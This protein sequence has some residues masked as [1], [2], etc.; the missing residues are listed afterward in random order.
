MFKPVVIFYSIFLLYAPIL[1]ADDSSID[2]E[3][4]YELAMRY[5][6]GL[7]NKEGQP[8][9]KKA[10]S[11][12]EATVEQ[13]HSK[14]MYALAWLYYNGQGDIEPNDELAMQLFERA[15]QNDL[16]EAQYMLGIMYAQGRGGVEKNSQLSLQWMK[17]AADQEYKPAQ[18]IIDS[19]FGVVKKP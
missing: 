15:A 6:H 12:L 1:Y 5:A 4:Q 10:K 17:K 16:A 13:E 7:E 11:L 9:Y 8:N 19:L 3:A 2:V 14:S 18:K